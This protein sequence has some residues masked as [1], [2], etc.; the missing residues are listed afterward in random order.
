MSSNNRFA[1]IL[2]VLFYEYLAISIARSLIPR[3][4]VDAFGSHSYIAVGIMET[5]KG[6]SGF[7]S[8]TFPLTF[9]YISDLVDKKDRAPAYGLAL[10]TFG[11]SFSLGPITA[12]NIEIDQRPMQK[13]RVAIEYLPYSWNFSETFRIFSLDPFLTNLALIVFMYYTAVWA[14]ISTLMVY[15]TRHLNF[16][17]VTLGW[18]LSAFGIATMFS[19]GVLVRIIVPLIG[20][21]SS[22]KLGLASFAIQCVLV[23]FSNSKT[24]IFGS[25]FFSMISHLVYPS[26]SS[27]VSKLVD[28]DVQ[29]EA[30]GALN[31]IKALTEGFGP[32]IFGFLMGLFEDS[33]LPGA[34]FLV[35]SVL[36]CWALLHCFELPPQPELIIAKHKAKIYGDSEG[37]SLLGVQAEGDGL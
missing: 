3:M 13:L 5:V 36:S 37:I 29:G 25:I 19:E 2:P 18:L 14:I 16:S 4:I 12:K 15:V 34:P 24:L 10:A 17:H 28:E 20:E 35:A 33:P 23:A 31:G 11:L 8:A 21:L 6:C 7:F 30:L 9:A 1:L 32:L 26:L 22:M 27:L